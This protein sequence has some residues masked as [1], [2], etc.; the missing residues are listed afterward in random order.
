M[1]RVDR[2][3]HGAGDTRGASGPVDATAAYRVVDGLVVRPMPHVLD[4]DRRAGFVGISADTVGARHLAM[5]LAILPPGAVAAPHVHEHHETGIHLIA[6]R[7]ELRWGEGLANR[8]VCQAGD[9]ILTPAGQ[10]H[11]PRNLSDTEPAVVI[12]ART[13]PRE[14]EDTTPYA[15]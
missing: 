15:T 4:P 1:S 12:F 3:G 8:T 2:H 13:D 9:F 5:G 14:H 10:P 6:G 7:V 11:Q